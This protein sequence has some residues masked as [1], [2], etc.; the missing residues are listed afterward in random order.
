M[1]VHRYIDEMSYEEFHEKVLLL[2]CTNDKRLEGFRAGSW[3]MCGLKACPIG[4][5]Q[6]FVV[7]ELHE[8]EPI[9]VMGTV[10]PPVW[11]QKSFDDIGD[12]CDESEAI[13]Y[14]ADA[15]K[16]R[17]EIE[18]TQKENARPQKDVGRV[19]EG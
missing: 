19:E 2:G 4:D 6:M 5:G 11:E 15:L 12:R 13:G 3:L 7:Y 1:H 17:H 14:W 8:V 16:L 10:C 9:C 18:E